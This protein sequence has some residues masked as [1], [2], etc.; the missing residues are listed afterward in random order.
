MRVL[1]SVVHAVSSVFGC[2]HDRLSRPF[3]I[4][5]Q[6]YMVCLDCGHQVFYSMDEMRRLTRREVRRLRVTAAG[7]MPPEKE[8]PLAA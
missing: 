6:S 8:T 1:Y 2:Q 7:K 5:H 3:T 4:A